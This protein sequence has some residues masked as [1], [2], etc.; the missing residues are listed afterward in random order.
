MGRGV[1]A[2]RLLLDVSWRV[3]VMR[4]AWEY[5]FAIVSAVHPI[6]PAARHICWHRRAVCREVRV[7]N[8]RS[9]PFEHRHVLAVVGGV[10]RERHRRILADVAN[11]LLSLAC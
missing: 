9:D 6:P 11:L 1:R 5:C 10:E 2:L 7:I 3:M 8:H 4:I